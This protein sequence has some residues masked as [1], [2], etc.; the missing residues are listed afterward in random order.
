MNIDDRLLWNNGSILI[1]IRELHRWSKN[2]LFPDPVTLFH[3]WVGLKIRHRFQRLAERGFRKSGDA[4]DRRHYTAVHGSDGNAEWFKTDTD[5]HL[6]FHL[7]GPISLQ[8]IAWL[9]LNHMPCLLSRNKSATWNK[10][11]YSSELIHIIRLL[12]DNI[13]RQN[14]TILL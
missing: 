12:K 14:G 8:P 3:H 2:T 10:Q 9:H 6:R 11:R 7:H 5:A 4:F 1:G 13:G